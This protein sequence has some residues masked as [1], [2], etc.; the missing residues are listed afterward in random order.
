MKTPKVSILVPIYN[1]TNFIE[2]CAHSLFQQTFL[3]IEYIFVNDC[4]TDD[5]IDKLLNVIEL[6]PLLKD[7]IQI[8]HHPN[9]RGLASTRN[10]AINASKGEYIS[11][12]DS[13]DYIEPNMIAELY[14]KAL[15]EHADITVCDFFIEFSDKTVIRID[16]I[17][18][19]KWENFRQMII[20]NTT[21]S[22][23]WNKL[24]KRSFYEMRECRVPDGL[25]SSEDR[26]VSSR[27][28]YFATKIVKVD[29]PLYHYVQYNANAITKTKSSMHFENL[30]QFWT[31][32]DDFLIE[33]G[34]L[35]KYRLEVSQSKARGKAS[36]MINTQS[37]SLQKKY[38][39][40]FLEEEKENTYL[41]AKGERILLF[42]LR[43]KLYI[44]A[45]LFQYLLVFKNIGKFKL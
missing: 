11:V 33:H 42:L 9:N 43:S 19:D 29:K 44:L 31:L 39:Y 7:Q 25:N 13:D 26:H 41:L 45:L 17:C 27:L 37:Y 24:V 6:Y 40:L 15:Q 3:D 10:T 21:H 28:F 12:V 14:T 4:S 20:Q 2:R 23:L 35:E 1:V 32:F 34:L 8:I 22:C 36:I 16:S 18:S 30:I 5:S 38:S